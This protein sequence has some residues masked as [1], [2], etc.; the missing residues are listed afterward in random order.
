MRVEKLRVEGRYQGPGR[1]GGSGGWW[2]W[3]RR[4]WQEDEEEGASRKQQRLQAAAAHTGPAGGTTR[5]RSLRRADILQVNLL[6]PDN[7]LTT[8]SRAVLA[9]C[10]APGTA[11]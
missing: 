4:V 11:K 5:W 9:V 8:S 1:D 7:T 2:W 10:S 6:H 3:Q